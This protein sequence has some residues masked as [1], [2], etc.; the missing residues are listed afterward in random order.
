MVNQR[1]RLVTE[2]E[3][4]LQVGD[5]F[6]ARLGNGYGA[7]HTVSAV[8]IVPGVGIKVFSGPW[9]NSWYWY[10]ELAKV[11]T[12]EEVVTKKILVNLDPPVLQR[13]PEVGRFLPGDEVYWDTART[14]ISPKAHRRYEVVR[15]VQGDDVY[16]EGSGWQPAHKLHHLWEEEVQ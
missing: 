9:T 10:H 16:F 1:T 11:V 6:C 7:E 8:E 2:G 14:P 5:T 15:D 13:L 12:I 4:E 3:L